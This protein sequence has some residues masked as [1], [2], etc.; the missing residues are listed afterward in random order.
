VGPPDVID[1]KTQ[2]AVA[3]VESIFRRAGYGLMG[4]PPGEVPP[5]LGREDLPDF[6]AVPPVTREQLG[7]RPVKV[8]YR[9][10]VD[11]YL[12]VES[13]RGARSFCALAKQYWPGLV[14]VFVSDESESRL[15][16]FRVLDLATWDPGEA[17]T[18]VE[19]AA[20]P[21]LNIYQL[22]VE[23]HEALARRLMGVLSM[24][25]APGAE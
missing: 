21:S 12:A 4:F 13:R 5:H 14:V 11:Q 24:R 6:H 8:R 2:V 15:S 23:E 22:N 19:L 7:S 1:L 10:R 3:L 18:L 25:R 20:H 9:R 16:C 17:L